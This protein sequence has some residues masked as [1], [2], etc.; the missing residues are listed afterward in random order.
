MIYNIR[1]TRFIYSKKL[2]DRFLACQL[3][4]G[5]EADKIGKRGM[6][7]TIIEI[8]S[9]WSQAVS[10]GQIMANRLAREFYR[11][12][13]ANDVTNFENAVRTVNEAIANNEL[14]KDPQWRSK[15]N[16]FL[17]LV[18][19]NEVHF[20]QVGN[21]WA[22]IYRK[23]KLLKV[24]DPDFNLP[25]Q[26]NFVFSSLTSGN[27]EDD[28]ILLVGTK[29]MLE[30]ATEV[31]HMINH[32]SQLTPYIIGQEKKQQ[33]FGGIA[34]QI[35]TKESLA[36]KETANYPD[37]VYL[38]Q[39]LELVGK[40]IQYKIKNSLVPKSKSAYKKTAHLVNRSYQFSKEKI[41]PHITK[42]Y[43]F[44]KS[45]TK[46]NASKI[47][48]K[49]N[50]KIKKQNPKTNFK[51]NYYSTEANK[52]ATKASVKS[53]FMLRKLKKINIPFLKGKRRYITLAVLLCVILIVISYNR[54]DS[55]NKPLNQNE[56]KNE[57]TNLN[58]QIE[59]AKNAILYEENDK[60]RNILS[61]SIA[62]AEELIKRGENSIELQKVLE[63]L[64]KELDK[65]DK[66][67]RLTHEIEITSPAD[68][69]HFFTS[70]GKIFTLK[71]DGTIQSAPAAG[72][73]FNIE[74]VAKVDNFI[75]ATISE[76]NN[77]I[78][79]L[80]QNKI[81]HNFS[82]QNN[83]LS[84]IDLENGTWE[85]AT[86][87]S[88]YLN[89]L[90]LINDKADNIVKYT[91]RIDK[92]SEGTIYLSKPLDKMIRSITIDGAIYTLLDNGTIK[93]IEKNK[94]SDFTINSLPKT[95]SSNS[96]TKIF[97]SSDRGYLYISTDKIIIVVNKEGYFVNQYGFDDL[98]SI[99]NFFLQD[100]GN[101]IWILSGRKIRS[102]NLR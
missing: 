22:D 42:S 23:K 28:D 64:R 79:I 56:V 55:S 3:A 54:Y 11:G 36:D 62:K 91:A 43:S 49:L 48:Q 82:T 102:Y 89:N 24:S 94:I 53:L 41:W 60:A 44:V 16:A 84:K 40:K 73:E 75:S 69:K 37:T 25:V 63:E 95:I 88:S 10:I 68:T 51:I 19:E 61:D 66:I 86:K 85:N 46:N 6:I 47:S 74:P 8:L 81:M 31:E 99:D 29:H 90:Y 32:P 5:S 59:E 15:I 30:N 12:E 92:F 18:I 35:N 9:P 7:V 83:A 65:L 21:I 100:K 96:F 58:N 98:D 101:T 76:K 13:S 72:G 71:K 93:K 14:E 33:I 45:K 78:Y 80:D 38:D 4:T 50:N 67:T 34:L 1:H 57:I 70:N 52:L 26:S 87:M 2:P 97:T 77:S 39:P 17:A 27:L 20:T